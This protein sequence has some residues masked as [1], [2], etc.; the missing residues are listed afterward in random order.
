[1]N[2]PKCGNEVTADKKF[3]G[4]C[5]TPVEPQMTADPK[6]NTAVPQSKQPKKAADSKKPDNKKDGKKNTGLKITAIVLVIAVLLCGLYSAI[7]GIINANEI[8]GDNVT[9]IDDFPIL[10]NKAGFTVY[11][12]DK[13]PFDEYEIRV[14]RFHMGGIL[15]NISSRSE[16]FSDKSSDKV[17]P[18]E[19]ED[20]EYRV[21]L[22]NIVS[23]R[24][25]TLPQ[26]SAETTSS[27]TTET[28]TKTT[29]E[30]TT[31]STTESTTGSTAE[32]TTET[33]TVTTE[34]ATETTTVTTTVTTTEST[35]ESTSDTTSSTQADKGG[36][37]LN[38]EI[39]IIIDIRV[40][41]SAPEAVESVN[42]NSKA[43]DV[44]SGGAVAV[45][46]TEE[47]L[48]EFKEMVRFRM[49]EEWIITD[50][51]RK[52]FNYLEPFD[53]NTSTTQYILENVMCNQADGNEIFRHLF[54]DDIEG[55]SVF[56][57]YEE[58]KEF[59]P[60]GKF[61]FNEEMKSQKASGNSL[62][63]ADDEGVMHINE[64]G[65]HKIPA[66]KFK[67]ICEN[68][69][70]T[71]YD[72]SFSET[73]EYKNTK[74]D[75]PGIYLHGDY[76]YFVETM[77]YAGVTLGDIEIV[78]QKIVDGKYVFTVALHN[79]KSN[80]RQ[81]NPADPKVYDITA[82]L[83][84]ID[85]KRVWSFYK[86]AESSV[87]ATEVPAT[88]KYK[89]GDVIKFGKY[90]QDNNT[91]NGTE[92]IEWKVID[93]KGNNALVISKYVLDIRPYSGGHWQWEKASLRDWLNADFYNDAFSAED[94]QKIEV[95][96]VK[97]KKNSDKNKDQ[98]SDTQDKVF[99]LSD[100]EVKEYFT[101]DNERLC[102][103]TAYAVGD[104]SIYKN[105]EPY[106]DFCSWWVRYAVTDGSTGSDASCVGIK[107]GVGTY[108]M[109]QAGCGVR[110]AMWI[111]M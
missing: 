33:T 92:D 35:A 69:F 86:I 110:P 75:F 82:E 84:N 99:I 93:V 103:P 36:F 32:S 107:G 1:M 15:K 26:T 76:V 11:D 90:E 52:P 59:D 98:G 48:E 83:K 71:K 68:V 53:C 22:K 70:N 47:D 100:D 3:C 34:S 96:T 42:L 106:V 39:I 16:V 61:C 4:K 64:T 25:Q 41:G 29:S 72:P 31:E 105:Y 87:D 49:K 55:E 81:N 65:L 89:V 9:Y 30:P 60:L 27:T 67:W 46:A 50:T 21:T 109:V 18:L 58:Y 19:L 88:E 56:A 5:G 95:T 108:G 43:S 13:F 104:R 85:G 45:E 62:V 24:T 23:E 17:Y 54:K 66:E 14:E 77:M 111:E 91:S 74:L 2:C 12:E 79:E 51:T 57:S 7:F 63:Y 10:K 97:A 8:K 101:T 73:D 38:I 78:N 37:N 94:Q 80:V 102:K 40:K 44:T 28:T 20:G 6:I